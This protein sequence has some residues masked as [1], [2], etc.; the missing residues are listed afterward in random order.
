[1]RIILIGKDPLFAIFVRIAL[2]R[3]RNCQVRLMSN[4]VIFTA[5]MRC[6]VP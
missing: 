6:F 2:L 1:M 5:P 4:G 3:A